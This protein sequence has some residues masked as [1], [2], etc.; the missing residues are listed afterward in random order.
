MSNLYQIAHHHIC[1]NTTVE[2]GKCYDIFQAC[3]HQKQYLHLI[4][5]LIISFCLFPTN[6]SPFSVSLSSCPLST[7]PPSVFLSAFRI[8]FISFSPP[9]SL[10]LSLCHT[11]TTYG[12]MTIYKVKSRKTILNIMIQIISLC[13]ESDAFNFS[14]VLLI[15]SLRLKI[16]YQCDTTFSVYKCQ[17]YFQSQM[18]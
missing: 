16:R 13:K 15:M 10:S 3:I 1:M 8:C 4:W 2:P 12:N 11:Y 18:N 17:K 6:Y 7:S 9:C 14:T 5:K